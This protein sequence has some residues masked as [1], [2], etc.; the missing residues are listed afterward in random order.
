MI[1][2]L[3]HYDDSAR[4]VTGVQRV[5]ELFHPW[6]KVCAVE[7]TM[8]VLFCFFPSLQMFRVSNISHACSNTARNASE[9]LRSASRI[10]AIKLYRPCLC[11]ALTSRSCSSLGCR[12][13]L[14][15]ANSGGKCSFHPF[16]SSVVAICCYP[17]AC[18]WRTSSASP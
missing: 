1:F 14:Q 8:I 7:N 5:K 10:A 11:L 13:S 17:S 4:Y 18:V 3:V 6:N 15:A 12:E 16:K 9:L 2:S